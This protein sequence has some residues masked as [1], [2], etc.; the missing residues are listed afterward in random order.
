M[1][2]VAQQTSHTP[3]QRR[4]PK[5]K[6]AI[7][8]HGLVSAMLLATGNAKAVADQEGRAA[9]PNNMAIA[10][11]DRSNT[12]TSRCFN[13][14]LRKCLRNITQCMDVNKFTRK[15]LRCL[16][17]ETRSEPGSRCGPMDRCV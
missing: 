3:D 10:A 8:A 15:L 5:M 17:P 7:I 1:G 11:Q 16:A 9:D 14:V 4:T 2:T 12:A 6:L 13:D